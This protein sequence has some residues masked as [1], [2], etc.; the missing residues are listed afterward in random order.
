M[1]RQAILHELQLWCTIF[2]NKLIERETREPLSAEVLLNV[3]CLITE[4]KTSWSVQIQ[5]E[6]YI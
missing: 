6:S 4:L 5:H 3:I 1:S 2:L